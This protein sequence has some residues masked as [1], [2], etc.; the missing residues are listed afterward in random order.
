MGP[1]CR[2]EFCR[3]SNLRS[4]QSLSEEQRQRIFDRFWSMMS[5]EERRSNVHTLVNKVDIKQKKNLASR[6]K[7]SFSYNLKLSD[8]TSIPVCKSCFSSTLGLSQRTVVSWLQDENNKPPLQPKTPKTGKCVPV[9]EAD[10]NFLKNWLTNLPSLPSHYCRSV[11]AYKNKKFLYPGTTKAN[12]YPLYKQAATEAGARVV[13]EKLFSRVFEA[14]HFSVFI[15]RKDQCDVCVSAKHGN[16]D[17][18]TLDAHIQAK[19]R[20]RAEK[21]KDKEAA[22][23]EL[24]VWTMD[25]QAVLLC[26]KSKASK[27]Y[28]KTKMQVHNFTLMNLKTKEGCCYEWDETEGNLGSEVF[29]YLQWKHFDRVI[30]NNPGI[31]TIIIWSDGC[32]YQ[33]R[34]VTVTNAFLNLAMK[35][36]IRIIQKYLVPG[37]T[38]MECDSMHSTIERKLDVCE[39]FTPH[40]YVVIFQ[41]ARIRPS[42]YHVFEVYHDQ[43]MKL[44][45]GYVQS[46]RPGKRAGDATVHQLRALCYCSSGEIQYKLD[47]N[48]TS[49]WVTLPQRISIPNEPLEWVRHFEGQMPLSNRKFND[50]QAMKSVMPRCVHQY[51]DSLPHLEA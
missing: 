47:F 9:G 51:Y 7:T 22:N 16:L 21:S 23:D 11:P 15:P 35:H 3:K 32:G 46:I 19:D 50:L 33:N 18:A 31:K 27:L 6:R 8:A 12:L 49:D 25:L 39:I 1:P 34:N 29:A 14:E 4:C 20:A 40:D 17:Q 5:W 42:P 38:Q 28:Y 41:S 24:S 43:I 30:H 2:S 37:H 44:D 36:D 13:G 48:E 10:L 26:P 45:G